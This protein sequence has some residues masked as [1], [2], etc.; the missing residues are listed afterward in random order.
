MKLKSKIISLVVCLSLC[1]ATLFNAIY[2]SDKNIETHQTIMNKNEIDYMSLLDEFDEKE[3]VV[4]ENDVKL[5]A[6]QYLD[7]DFLF[8]LDNLNYNEML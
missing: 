2:F 8:E 3:L 5:V 7:E 6:V 1:L 4:E